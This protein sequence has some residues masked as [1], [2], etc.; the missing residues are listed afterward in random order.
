M[1]QNDA[2]WPGQF[3]T[4]NLTLLQL[5]NAVVVL[6]QAV[7]TGQ[8]GEFVYVVK[9]DQTAEQ[10]PVTIGVAYGDV[11]E[12]KSGLQAGET[13]VTDG[14]LR[15][16]PGTPVNIKSPNTGSTNPAAAKCFFNQFDSIIF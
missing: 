13:V 1:N 10:R 6:N 15:L 2:L 12:I 3:V 5:T 7:Q 9:S 11:T 14:Q 16:A 4:V 8:N